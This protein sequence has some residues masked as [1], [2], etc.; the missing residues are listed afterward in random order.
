MNITI[1]LK[2][3]K[4]FYRSRKY[5]VLGGVFG[6]LGDYFNIDPILLR[7]PFMILFTFPILNPYLVW[8]YI[9]I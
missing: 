2:T 8:T 7:I 6:G 1:K 9:I 4:R 3:M 5:S